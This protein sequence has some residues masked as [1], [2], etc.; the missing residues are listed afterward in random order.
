[1][2]VLKSMTGDA[3]FSCAAILL[4]KPN[5]EK[6]MAIL[7]QRCADNGTS[8]RVFFLVIEKQESLLAVWYKTKLLQ[9]YIVIIET[10]KG[11]A[12]TKG[13]V[14]GIAALNEI[15]ESE[16]WLIWWSTY[17]R[18]THCLIIQI[19]FTSCDE[20]HTL[21]SSVTLTAPLPESGP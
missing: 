2:T 5:N 14:M 18:V 8:I 9:N 10:K 3:L 12:A 7:L 20:I 1:M 13:F 21:L 17:F 15:L 16:V 6:T 11:N 19:L 4:M